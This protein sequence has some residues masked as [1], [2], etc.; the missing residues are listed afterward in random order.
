MAR[1]I[2]TLYF[3]GLAARTITILFRRASADLSLFRIVDAT[4]LFYLLLVVL[5]V[6]IAATLSWLWKPYAYGHLAALGT[7]L[8]NLAE[9]L[10]A[11]GIAATHREQAAAAITASRTER[12]LPVREEAIA[13]MTSPMA[14]LVFMVFALTFAAVL[15]FLILS[16]KRRQLR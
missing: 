9:T 11:L 7:V 13:M 16:V 10:I 6:L 8:V 3:S 4:P 15:C 1:W 2:I 14:Q 5:L 12:G